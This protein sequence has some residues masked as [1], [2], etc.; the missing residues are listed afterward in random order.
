MVVLVWQAGKYLGIPSHRGDNSFWDV[1]TVVVN[2]ALVPLIVSP[3]EI[4]LFSLFT[5]A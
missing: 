1:F 3:A 2:G 5:V 4:L